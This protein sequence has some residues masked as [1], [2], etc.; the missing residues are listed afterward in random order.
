MKVNEL[1]AYGWP[2][3]KSV[4]V[5]TYTCGNCGDHVA[6]GRG[7][8]LAFH[9]D[10]S[11]DAVGGLYLCPRCNFPT[12]FC[13]N[14][15]QVPGERIGGDVTHVPADVAALYD[16]ARTC[17]TENCHTAAVLI[18]RKILMNLAVS[19]GATAGLR[20]IE[21]VEF[22]SSAG[23]VPPNGKH[24][25]DHIRTK[26]NEAT[27]E[28]QLMGEQEARELLLFIEMLLRFIYEFPALVPKAAPGTPV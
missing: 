21:Y 14:G 20:F 19:V 3:A 25:V 22:L 2:T 27:H 24:W 8:P 12:Q 11:G 4:G 6:S 26:G 28:I 23:Y 16:E 7:Y 10:G 17:A 13:P 1:Y 18:C 9:A 15:S 5:R